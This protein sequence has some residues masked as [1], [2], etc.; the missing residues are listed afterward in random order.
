MQTAM[1]TIDFARPQGIIRP[2]HGVNLGPL[3]NHGTLDVSS[4]HRELGIPFTRLHDC[5]YYVR[6]VAD[7]HCIFRN[8]DA[9]P[10]HAENYSF[11]ETDDYIQSILNVGSQIV[12]RLGQSI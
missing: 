6:D 5:T 11:A 7:I 10:T 4:H 3:N 8:F 1:I 12:Y 2:L 9:D